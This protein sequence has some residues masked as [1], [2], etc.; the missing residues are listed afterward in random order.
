MAD[1]ADALCGALD[2]QEKG[3]ATACHLT[4]GMD[5]PSFEK[6]LGLLLRWQQVR[7]LEERF[8]GLGG[9]PVDHPIAQLAKARGRINRR[10]K[11][12]ME[13][14]NTTLYE[15]FGQRRID[16]D[17]ATKIYQALLGPLGD[18]DLIYATTNYD[19]AGETALQ[20]LGYEIDSGFRSR[21]HRTPTLDP[22]GLVSNRGAKTPVIHLH[23]A[24][25][26]YERDG[27]VGEHHA[28]MPYNPSLGTPVVLY[29]D[30]DKDPTSDAV[31]SQL[32]TELHKALKVAD[33]VFVIGHSLHD[34]ALVRALSETAK[35]K[36][37]AISFYSE[38]DA[39]RIATRIPAAA[40]FELNF[41]PA[42]TNAEL[43][44]RDLGNRKAPQPA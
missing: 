25:G 11:I 15:Q 28:D 36:L 21:P 8:Q 23:G 16:D 7:H 43:I 12:V 9:N 31:V 10:M 20:A 39:K 30:P 35:S 3:L 22:V 6:N 42:A 40:G 27:S 44:F 24:V 4:S 17:R 29:P 14:L 5:G 13:V 41:D 18:S 19:R 32:W 26:W 37:V 38:E 33:K 34:P 1:W 2:E